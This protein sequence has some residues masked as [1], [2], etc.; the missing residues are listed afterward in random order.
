MTP[1]F[2]LS[3]PCLEI[4]KTKQ[5]YFSLLG[6][7]SGRQKDNWVDINLY[8]NQITFIKSG[9]YNFSYKN[10][11]LEGNVLPSFHFGVILSNLDWQKLYEKIKPV[12]TF[13]LDETK[14]LLNKEGEHNSFFVKDPNGY[15]VEF[16]SFLDEDSVF[17]V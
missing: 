11:K 7:N 8:G 15:I 17:A 5:F 2:H 12:D 13:Y 14:Y 16:K 9:Y 3:L 6:A 1:T 4:E 10:Y